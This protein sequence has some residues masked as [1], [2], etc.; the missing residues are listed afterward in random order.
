MM[1][2]NPERAAVES[3]GAKWHVGPRRRSPHQVFHHYYSSLDQ[4]R[5]TRA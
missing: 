4:E 1:T 5:H 2:S 3:K